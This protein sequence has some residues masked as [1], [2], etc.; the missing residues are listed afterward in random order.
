MLYLA[1]TPKAGITIRARDRVS[2]PFSHHTNS[3]APPIDEKSIGGSRWL[4]RNRKAPPI[5]RLFVESWKWRSIGGS[6]WNGMIT[7]MH[8]H[9]YLIL[10]HLILYLH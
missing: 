6:R 9:L 8:M 7:H 1:P 5:E 10:L 3:L 4:E 2:H